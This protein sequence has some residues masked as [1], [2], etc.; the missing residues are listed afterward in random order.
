MQLCASLAG[1]YIAPVTLSL[2]VLP[3]GKKMLQR[4]TLLPPG[5]ILDREAG[6]AFKR[7]R[8]FHRFDAEFSHTDSRPSLTEP[9]GARIYYA[10]LEIA[11]K[12]IE[13][14]RA[15]NKAAAR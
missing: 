13:E 1:H 11:L 15:W 5:T 9:E 7:Q 8:G 3:G 12:K 2:S 10:N 4:L 6:A 14:S